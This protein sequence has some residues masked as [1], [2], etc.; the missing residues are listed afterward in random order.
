MFKVYQEL[1]PINIQFFFTDYT[2]IT[3][4]LAGNLETKISNHFK[5]TEAAIRGVFSKKVFLKISQIS[6]ENTCVGV[7]F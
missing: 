3:T 6:Q 1:S 4:T 2:I 7:S 5:H